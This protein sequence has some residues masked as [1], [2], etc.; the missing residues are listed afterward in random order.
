[1]RSF[2]WGT[3]SQNT[4]EIKIVL[5]SLSDPNPFIT[6]KVTNQGESRNQELR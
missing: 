6:L 2:I 3:A 4:I 1:M 5:G